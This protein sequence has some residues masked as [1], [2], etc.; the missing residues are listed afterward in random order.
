MTLTGTEVWLVLL[1]SLADG[2]GIVKSVSLEFLL[3]LIQ[4]P[5]LGY[6]SLMSE[7]F[8]MDSNCKNVDG[9]Q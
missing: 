1:L 4:A 9:L 7:N 2:L 8:V 5:P 6:F 3:L